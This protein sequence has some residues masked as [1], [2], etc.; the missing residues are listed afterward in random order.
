SNDDC[1]DNDINIYPGAAEALCNFIDDN[2]NAQ[3]DEGNN[4][5]LSILSSSDACGGIDNGSAELQLTNGVGPFQISIDTAWAS[6]VISVSSQY[7]TFSNGWSQHDVLGAPNTYPAYGDIPSAWASSTQD[8]QREFLELGFDG[9]RVVNTILIY[10]TYAPGA[11][12]SV[13]V[14]DAQL[15]TWIPVYLSTTLSI[16]NSSSILSI[17]VSYSN[18]IDAVRIAI[19]SP[20][21]PDWNEI[22]AVAIIGSQGSIIGNTVIGLAAGQNT[23]SISAANG[24][25]AEAILSIGSGV[26]MVY[27]ADVDNDTYGNPYDSIVSCIVPAGYV[28][29]HDDCDDTNASAHVQFIY[30]AD[31]D[32]DG[33]GAGPIVY[34]CSAT[35]LPGYSVFNSDCDD[36]DNLINTPQLYHLDRDNDG[37]G[38]SDSAG[39]IYSCSNT[40]PLGYLSDSTD[41]NDYLYS[42]LDADNDGLGSL[43]LV[44]CG[45][46]SNI[47]CNDND[48]S[49][50]EFSVYYIDADGDGLGNPLVDTTVCSN[51]IPVGYID[52]D[53]D[54]DD[55]NASILHSFTFYRDYDLDGYGDINND[56]IVCTAVPPTGYLS[57]FLDCDD[58]SATLNLSQIYFAD[59]DEDGY[60]DRNNVI[61]FCSLIPPLGYLTDSTDCDDGNASIHISF[62]FYS[63]VDGDGFGAFP[64]VSSC[65]STIPSGYVSNDDDC[66]DNELQYVDNDND[67][68]GSTTL[69]GCGVVN[70]YDCDDNNNAITVYM[71]Y[72]DLDG[73]GFGSG[74]LLISCDGNTPVGYASNN[75]DCNDFS[76]LHADND[77]DGYGAILPSACGIFDGSDCNDNDSLFSFYIYYEDNDGDGFGSTVYLRSCL[78]S[79]P[80][81]Y[82]A[83]TLDCDDQSLMYIDLDGDGV[84][85][86]SP[87][88]CGVIDGSDCNDNDST[89]SVLISFYIDADGDGFGSIDSIQTVC[90]LGSIAGF[91]RNDDDCDDALIMYFDNDNDGYGSSEIVACGVLNSLD[92]DDKDSLVSPA[93]AEFICNSID[94]DCD[95][96]V[97]EGN[98]LSIAVGSI[99]DA[100]GSNFNGVIN[101][102]ISGGN[103]AY[104]LIQPL[105]W[106]DSILSFSSQLGAALN[107]N[108]TLDMLGAPDVYPAYGDSTKAWSSF[109]PDNSREFV[110]LGFSPHVDIAGVLAYETFN[111]GAID[112]FYVRNASNQQWSIIYNDSIRPLPDTITP[113]SVII[114]HRDTLPFPVD[115]VRIALNSGDVLGANQV[116]A[117]G[118]VANHG[119]ISG[120]VISNMPSGTYTITL[121]DTTN[122]CPAEVLATIGFSGMH[123]WFKDQ[124]GDGYGNTDSSI[125]ASSQPM[126]YSLIMG[127]CNDAN[128][129]INPGVIDICNN[130]LDDNCNGLIDE[131]CITWY[132]DNDSDSYGNSS[133]SIISAFSPGA[134]YVIVAGDCNDTDSLVNPGA[135]EVCA[136][137]IDDN[138]DGQID[139]NCFNQATLSIKVF[140]EGFYLGNG[141]MQAVLYNE[142]LSINPNVCDSVLIELRDPFS[143]TSIVAAYP[144]ILY[145]NGIANTAH[146]S[147]FSGNAFYI[148]VKHRNAIET[149]SKI[150]VTLG[151]NV[152]FDFTTP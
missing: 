143:P 19:N 72:V 110:E 7:S 1:N 4:F 25:R 67:T 152:F 139:E 103:G 119:T 51:V 55:S 80:V 108:S 24:C 47:D 32:F 20:A 63:D 12:D 9:S 68:F 56:T 126:G 42:Y 146:S 97:D 137:L 70:N 35:P 73:D 124:D 27:Y 2:C 76:I 34:T 144:S 17:P 15:G 115:A 87:I 48:S 120:N 125:V 59:V 23:I 129:N 62:Y 150:P 69:A 64:F 98:P 30:Y 54:C 94:D 65:S 105:K 142:G 134:N 43:T 133:A 86:G 114:S 145:T 36:N 57:D 53:L 96:L 102:N 132:L 89:V 5:A 66:N 149:W 92:C 18:S 49:L 130:A 44:A 109:N 118:V 58:S 11:I 26:S 13:Y 91:V 83:D 128:I 84:G 121:I 78:L 39:R 81:G 136:N 60:G 113:H 101:L 77:N 38:S 122:K 16:G 61:S 138:C 71:Y 111:S 14:R 148:V 127:D 28:L 99:T 131:T 45:V 40:P 10:E 50:Q 37:F 141:V 6:S 95:G 106:A 3:I 123:T 88:P 147:L 85:S 33:Y 46:Y 151:T 41:C 90:S 117:V 93:E 104:Q 31:A 82:S 100:S 116:D 29:N 112:T 75:D 107:T 135:S 140:I 21:I 52:N 8:G 79:P 22:D 74:G